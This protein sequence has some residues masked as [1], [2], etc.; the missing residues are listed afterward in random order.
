MFGSKREEVAE[1]WRSLHSKE[2][3]NLYV[4]SIIRIIKSRRMRL[5]GHVA[6]MAELGITHK[7]LVG[8]LERKSPLGRPWHR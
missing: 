8:K 7:I 2:L 6:C 3:D 1:G 4:S 5:I